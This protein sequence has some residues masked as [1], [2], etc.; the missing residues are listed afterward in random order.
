MCVSSM[1]LFLEF[2]KKRFL[3]ENPEPSSASKCKA[4]IIYYRTPRDFFERERTT[5]VSGYAGSNPSGER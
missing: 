1:I 3:Q 2:K 5:S 4:F